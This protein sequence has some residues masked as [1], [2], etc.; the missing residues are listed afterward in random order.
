MMHDLEKLLNADNITDLDIGAL[1][2]QSTSGVDSFERNLKPPPP[3][4]SYSSWSPEVD[5]R[6]PPLS[7]DTVAQSG[8]D[9]DYPVVES[10]ALPTHD[11]TMYDARG[12]VGGGAVDG[13]VRGNAADGLMEALPGGIP[14]ESN[15]WIADTS[16]DVCRYSTPTPAVL[17]VNLI[18]S[19]F[20][21]GF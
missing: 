6:C 13:V 11:F 10:V 16:N 15:S 17:N 4:H 2:L 19:F 12:Q 8:R 9:P 18:H 5:A 1:A 20:T 3:Y 21:A 14:A 7:L